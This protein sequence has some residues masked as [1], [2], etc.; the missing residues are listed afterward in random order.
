MNGCFPDSYHVTCRPRE[1]S[2]VHCLQPEAAESA[3][4]AHSASGGRR[5]L[6]ASHGAEKF[7]A[8]LTTEM[9]ALPLC[10][11][12]RSIARLRWRKGW[13]ASFALTRMNTSA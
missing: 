7:S 3:F 1:G 10:A 9:G 13:I 8:S 12:C 2:A 6:S 4:L 5:P 11:C